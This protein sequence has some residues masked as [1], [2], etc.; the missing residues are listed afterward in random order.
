MTAPTDEFELIIPPGEHAERQMRLRRITRADV[1]SAI[2]T[3]FEDQP[4][5]GD[6]GDRHEGYAANGIHVLRVWILPGQIPSF[7]H[8]GDLTVKTVAWRGRR[9]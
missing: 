8:T 3:C 4:G 1:E 7:M 2:R 5:D 9:W 6:N